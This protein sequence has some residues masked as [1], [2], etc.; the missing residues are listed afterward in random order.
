MIE[1]LSSEPSFCLLLVERPSKPY[2][3][4]KIYKGKTS[5]D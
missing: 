3:Q 2:R 5:E 4:P 1:H